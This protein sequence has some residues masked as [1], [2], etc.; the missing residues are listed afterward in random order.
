MSEYNRFIDMWCLVAEIDSA[1]TMLSIYPQ[2]C[3]PSLILTVNIPCR[4]NLIIRSNSARIFVYGSVNEYPIVCQRKGRQTRY[5]SFITKWPPSWILTITIP[6]RE[7]LIIWLNS[8]CQVTCL[9]KVWWIHNQFCVRYWQNSKFM[10]KFQFKG[11][12]GLKYGYKSVHN[13]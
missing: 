7:K 13:R 9:S 12:R 2:K 10:E 3:L 8:A 1:D 4:E 6:C 5:F 11:V